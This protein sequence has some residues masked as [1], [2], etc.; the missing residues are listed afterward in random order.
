MEDW[1]SRVHRNKK[2]KFLGTTSLIFGMTSIPVSGSV[3]L[4]RILPFLWPNDSLLIFLLGWVVPAIALVFGV[5]SIALE[6]LRR[7][8]LV[9]LVIGIFSL[10]N[11]LILSP[12]I[13][14]FLTIFL[15]R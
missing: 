1:K 7:N 12:L 8:A 15:L 13:A 14:R 4:I 11:V 2:I 3:A 10:I 6:G 9:G 5:L